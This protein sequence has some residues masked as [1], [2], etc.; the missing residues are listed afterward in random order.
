[1]STRRT[2]IAYYCSTTGKWDTINIVK[3]KEIIP[4]YNGSGPLM[5][6]DVLPFM[7]IVR[8]DG[9]VIRNVTKIKNQQPLVRQIED[10]HKFGRKF[11]QFEVVIYPNTANEEKVLVYDRELRRAFDENIQRPFADAEYLDLDF[12][13]HMDPIEVS[14]LVA[15]E[16][17]PSV[18][19]T[20]H[21]YKTYVKVFKGTNRER[22]FEFV[23][24]CNLYN[25]KGIDV[26][27]EGTLIVDTYLYKKFYSPSDSAE[28]LSAMREVFRTATERAIQLDGV[29]D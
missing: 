16:H 24:L 4:Q 21:C 9:T 5:T 25:D 6:P 14:N 29:L 2:C 20:T 23:P 7:D 18:A 13:K 26:K 1:M 10:L 12:I 22:V 15:I 27:D 28:K 3:V 8:T 17:N 11:E 19:F